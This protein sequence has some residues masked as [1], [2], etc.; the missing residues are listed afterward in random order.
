VYR[1][2]W[3][4]ANNYDTA[5]RGEL[6]ANNNA[7]DDAATNGPTVDDTAADNAV[8]YDDSASGNDRAARRCDAHL[9]A[10]VT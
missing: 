2:L 7:A 4:A 3:A 6:R 5:V 1:E 8:A 9:G 10:I